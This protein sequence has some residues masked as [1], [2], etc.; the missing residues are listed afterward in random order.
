VLFLSPYLIPHLYL[1]NTSSLTPILRTSSI[2]PTIYL[3]YNYTTPT[4]YLELVKLYVDVLKTQQ[5]KIA[6]NEKRYRVGLDKLRETEDIVAKLEIKLT[7]MQPV[8]VKASEDASTLLA[9]V[10]VDQK[11]ADAQAAIVEVD[12]QEA[13]KVAASVKI[14][15]DDCQADL[16]EAMPAYESAV[17]ALATLDKKSVQEMKAFNN[18]PG[19]SVK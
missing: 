14:I 6:A 16:D 4:S 10:S 8:L 7:E 18:P 19:T 3:R 13:N 17:K 15:K 9:Q 1:P 2:T 12:V 5:H 11:E